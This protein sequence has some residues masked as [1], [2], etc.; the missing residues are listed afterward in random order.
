MQ[1]TVVHTPQATKYCE[2][3]SV[4]NCVHPATSYSCFASVAQ[5]HVQVAHGTRLNIEVNIGGYAADMVCNSLFQVQAF[6]HYIGSP[7]I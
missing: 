4:S 6:H 7:V 1:W 5:V 3:T 2:C